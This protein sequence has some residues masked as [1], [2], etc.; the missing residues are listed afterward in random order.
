MGKLCER[1]SKKIVT[2]CEENEKP[3][4]RPHNAL[5][6]K[7]ESLGTRKVERVRVR[8]WCKSQRQKITPKM[9]PCS[10]LSLVLLTAPSLITSNDKLRLLSW[11]AN[12]TR[13]GYVVDKVAAEGERALQVGPGCYE[14]T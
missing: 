14:F 7:R 3:C 13:Q 2:E 10:V 12:G 6:T 8:L 9:I 1:A 5:E 4:H 11:Y